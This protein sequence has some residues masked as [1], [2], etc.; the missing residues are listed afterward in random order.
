VRRTYGQQQRDLDVGRAAFGTA[1]PYI[2]QPRGRHHALRHVEHV[3]T[4]AR[5][6][7]ERQAVDPWRRWTHAG[8]LLRAG[9]QRGC[10]VL[11]T[12][13]PL[14]RR[15]DRRA[16]DMLRPAHVLPLGRIA[17]SDVSDDVMTVTAP[18]HRSRMS[19]KIII[20]FHL[21]VTGVRISTRRA[22]HWCSAS[23]KGHRSRRWI[24]RGR[25]CQC[26][27]GKSSDARTITNDMAPPRCS[28]R[29]T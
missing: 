12:R 5:T 13:G 19:D 8:S 11:R 25:C 1:W 14:G 3:H 29:W 26:G 9:L 22:V 27:P 6:A 7:G 18:R 24:A 15:L 20:A 28:P 23:M 16:N 17:M 4:P 2:T 21:R 10:G